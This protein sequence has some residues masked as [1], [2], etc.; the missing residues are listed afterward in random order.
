M[1]KN[2]FKPRRVKEREELKKEQQKKDIE[3]IE[4]KLREEGIQDFKITSL[5]D[6][7]YDITFSLDENLNLIKS[8]DQKVTGWQIVESININQLDQMSKIDPMGNYITKRI[9][10]I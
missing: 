6:R 9:L 10:E 5:E 2:I 3:Q 1:K 4:K 8:K 7:F